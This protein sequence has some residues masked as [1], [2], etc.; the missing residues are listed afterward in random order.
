MPGSLLVSRLL[1]PRGTASLSLKAERKARGKKE[2]LWRIPDTLAA[3][4]RHHCKH[5][6]MIA[7]SVS[8]IVASLVSKSQR[9][10]DIFLGMVLVSCTSMDARYSGCSSCYVHC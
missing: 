8:M 7:S 3:G 10:T 2:R 5:L 9:S 1:K 4:E 6:T